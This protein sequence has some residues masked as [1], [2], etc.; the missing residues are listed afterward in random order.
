ML[1]VTD[2]EYKLKQL[3]DIHE[4]VQFTKEVEKEEMMPFLDT[5]IVRTK[6]KF[7]FKVY[8]KPTNKEDYVHF[9]SAHSDRVKS[10]IVIGFFLRAFRICDEEY[11]DDEIKHIYES[12]EKLKYPRGFLINQ[13]TKA[14]RIIKKKNTDTAD[15][16]PPKRWITIPNSTNAEVI[17]RTL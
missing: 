6:E 17:S 9:Y 10:G 12:F 5:S 1:K 13:K 7:K 15:R 11:L 8:R 2:L 14:E 16:K 3:N 4:K